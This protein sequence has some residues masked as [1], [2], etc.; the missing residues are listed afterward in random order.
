MLKKN[1]FNFLINFNPLCNINKNYST[2]N[3][4]LFKKNQNFKTFH[5]NFIKQIKPI[6]VAIKKN[7]FKEEIKE[8]NETKEIKKK[9][10]TK[11]EKKFFTITTKASERLKELINSLEGAIGITISN[12]IIDNN[13]VIKIGYFFKHQNLENYIKIEDKKVN[14]FIHNECLHYVYGAELDFLKNDN[15]KTGD[16]RFNFMNDSCVC[17]ENN[18]LCKNSN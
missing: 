4:K 13:E 5:S 14:I 9:N 3:F 18:S 17:D 2:I 12:I 1:N 8:K 6:R 7:Q 11:C 10:E 16:F 15:S